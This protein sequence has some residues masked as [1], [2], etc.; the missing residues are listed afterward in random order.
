MLG[1]RMP[2]FRDIALPGD[3]VQGTP[4]AVD[5]VRHKQPFD[6][7]LGRYLLTGEKSAL[8][9][10]IASADEYIERIGESA[11]GGDVSI[12]GFFLMRHTPAW[13]GLLRLY[14]A[15]GVPFPRCRRLRRARQLMT[16][17]WTQPAPRI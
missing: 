2:V 9:R 5:P 13:E 11:P 8:E 15:T 4:A 10:A 17:M 3:G 1:G 7:W 12:P 14:E 6:E 16:G